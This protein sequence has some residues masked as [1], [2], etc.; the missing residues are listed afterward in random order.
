[1]SKYK[2][3]TR[4]E[5]S[6]DGDRAIH[7]S[8]LYKGFKLPT[9]RAFDLKQAFFNRLKGIKCYKEQKVL[10]DISFDVKKGE[11]IGIVGRNGSGNPLY[12]KL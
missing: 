11:F 10:N 9:E 7:V 12:L 8:N 3:G 6:T 2:I 1:M 4:K 5:I